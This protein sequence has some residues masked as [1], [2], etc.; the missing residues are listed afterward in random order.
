MIGE[1]YFAR[2]DHERAIAAYFKGAYGYPF[3]RWA[4]LCHFEAA[5]CFEAL[6]Q[7]EEARRSYRALVAKYPRHEKAGAAAERLEELG[8]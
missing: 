6:G 2:K 8:Q 4:G 7:V 1:C 3:D 5:R